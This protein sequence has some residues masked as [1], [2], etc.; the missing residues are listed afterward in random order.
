MN[1]C[2]ITWIGP[3]SP[4]TNS[5]PSQFC[6]PP[7]WNILIQGRPSS[8]LQL[9]KLFFAFFSLLLP[10]SQPISLSCF[11]RLIAFSPFCTG[12]VINFFL[13]LLD[14]IS[15]VE[16]NYIYDKSH[17]CIC[18]VVGYCCI[19]DKLH[20]F[21]LLFVPPELLISSGVSSH[22]HFITNIAHQCTFDRGALSQL[23]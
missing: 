18:F 11:G 13:Y 21:P 7:K 15:S 14:F 6:H 9:G 17:N 22:C 19:Y 2:H 12:Q 16:Y 3:F 1:S 5:P 20:Q 23:L 10:P 8:K 4:N